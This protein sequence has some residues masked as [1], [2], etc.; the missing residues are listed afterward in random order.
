M[1]SIFSSAVG[2]WFSAHLT[3]KLQTMRKW[4]WGER[5]SENPLS[6]SV[7]LWQYVF[8]SHSTLRHPPLKHT[9]AKIIPCPA[10]GN[11]LSQAI[12]QDSTCQVKLA[13]CYVVAFQEL[14][15]LLS[16]LKYLTR[17][18]N[19]PWQALNWWRMTSQVHGC[20]RGVYYLC[21]WS[22]RRDGERE[23]Y[24]PGISVVVKPHPLP[25]LC[26]GHTIISENLKDGKL[27]EI[28]LEISCICTDRDGA[29]W[30]D[31]QCSGGG[32]NVVRNFY[33]LE[34]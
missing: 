5:T 19:G 32:M 23:K 17:G 16:T 27:R 34:S 7:L 1:Y 18:R 15:S 6:P 14:L 21:H 3:E 12:N 8:R 31:Q 25:P 9:K 22:D 10:L 33:P 28:C 29:V 4:V 26:S 24:T 11:P 2:F 13:L 30:T 20:Y